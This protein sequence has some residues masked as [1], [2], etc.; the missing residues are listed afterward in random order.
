MRTLACTLPCHASR[1]RPRPLPAPPPTGPT[2]PPPRRAGERNPHATD[3]HKARLSTS[4]TIFR[5]F[6]LNGDGL[7]SYWEFLLVLTL[8]SIPEE[9]AAIIFR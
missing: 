6:D 9:D 4:R 7:L 1:S 8:L 2:A 5:Q 3:T